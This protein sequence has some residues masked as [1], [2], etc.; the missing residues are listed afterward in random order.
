MSTHQN[1]Q[2]KQSAVSNILLHTCDLLR[3]TV[4]PDRYKDY[5]L[6]MLFLKSLSDTYRDESHK[7]LLGKY[8]NTP[9]SISFWNLYELRNTSGN[10]K[11][12]DQ[13]LSAIEK[14]NYFG[15]ENIFQNISFDTDQLGSEKKRDKLL[16]NLLEIFGSSSLD[17]SI[18]E[19][20][21]TNLA[22]NA[23]EYL[24]NFFSTTDSKTNGEYYTP[25][26]ISTLLATLL[27]PVEGDNIYD[28]SCGSGS[29]LIE[30]GA[31]IHKKSSSKNY[32]LYGQE[33]NSSI[34]SLAKMNMFLHGEDNYLLKWGD[35]L[36]NPMLTDSNEN[37]PRFDI[38]ISNP[39]FSLKNWGYEELYNDPYNRFHR[40]M[41]PK[42]SGDYAFISHMVET[43]KPN[44]GRM[45]V[46]VPH[47]VLFRGA[48]EGEIRR[49]LIEENLLDT[50]IGLPANMLFSTSIAVA[51]L[52][53]KKDKTDNKILFI[54][55]SN[56][57]ESSRNQNILPKKS[58]DKIV[59]TYKNRQS[60][61]KYSYL[62]TFDEVKE[63][64]FNLNIPRYVD[65]TEHEEKIDLL[66]VRT[67]YLVL[68]SE[69]DHLG[70][71]I[72]S[73]FKN[74]GFNI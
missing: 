29:L 51:I 60:D 71:E 49:H 61:D 25:R 33:I 28:P 42:S 2:L 34:L 64:D 30:C 72:D 22:G 10:G 6:P 27:E 5:I 1:D 19:N 36:R 44:T 74:L 31:L 65:T 37:L 43:L 18:S 23:F 21:E 35:V 45:A 17:L 38:V 39:P 4:R 7:L 9:K 62:A 70:A 63:N 16:C 26:E 54:D 32:T 12:I 20:S 55:A 66:T 68:K 15:F 52:I 3:G 40:G 50:V 53:F 69:L 11:R 58:I 67:E 57:Y 24:L 14:D 48:S 8:S 13:A 59:Q 73:R 46:I 47:G 41:P 56:D